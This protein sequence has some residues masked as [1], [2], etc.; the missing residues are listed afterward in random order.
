M[1]LSGIL[2]SGLCSI[3]Y[4]QDSVRFKMDGYFGVNVHVDNNYTAADYPGVVDW[5][6]DY[7]D[8]HNFEPQNNTYT[9]KNGEL[10][11]DSAYA[12]VRN[13]GVKNLLV[14]EDIP[15]WISPAP[16]H[17][18]SGGFAP[19]G[20][21]KG[22]QPADYKEAAEFFYQFTARYGAASVPKKHLMSDDRAS[23]LDLMDALEVMNEADGDTSWGNFV[24]FPQYAALLN[25]V[26]D[27][28]QGKLGPKMGI[29]AA[30]PDM[31]VSIT[32][33]GDNLRS[34]QKIVK[35]CGRAPFDIVNLHFYAFRRI[36]ED[37]RV[38]IP[39]EWSSMEKDI[40]ETVSWVKENIP[41]K[42]I[43]LTEIGWDSEPGK[44]TEVV[45][46]QESADYLIRS[47]LLALGAGAEKCFW[48]YWKDYGT[49]HT[50]VFGSMGFFE[51]ASVPYKGETQFKPKLQYWYH[52]TMRNILHDS[53]FI[54]NNSRK[55][56]PTVY[57]FHFSTDD[58]LIRAMWYCPEYA[59][60]WRPLEVPVKS[61][62]VTVQMPEGFSHA[63]LLTPEEGS[64]TGREKALAPENGGIT[65]SLGST[66]VFVVFEK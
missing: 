48:Y 63:K 62:T 58:S 16:E 43:W 10:N 35:A 12:A 24:T 65:V 20:N 45:T 27:G 28:N 23:G 6:R 17:K 15:K 50:G 13:V 46:E 21:T 55:P 42:K 53:Y 54:L 25:A 36:R 34:L 49:N 9:F 32:G 7:S 11:F 60:D 39:P 51:S 2:L 38:A 1:I 64:T 44:N 37:Y 30:D 18:H 33:L 3:A 31:P 59:H 61:K 29:K 5:I 41:G 56:D 52:A 22:T 47:Y 40:S 66:P 19:K 8:W 57:D 14:I 26:Y 4:A